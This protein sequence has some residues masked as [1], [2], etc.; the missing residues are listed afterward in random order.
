[1]PDRYAGYLASFQQ[2]AGDTDAIFSQ[3]ALQTGADRHLRF[4]QDANCVPTVANV[5]LSPTTFSGVVL[6]GTGTGVGFFGSD[7]GGSEPS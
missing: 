6:N 4:V 3:S 1:M 7:G 2:W 5:T